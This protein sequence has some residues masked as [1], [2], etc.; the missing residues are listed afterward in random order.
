MPIR[1]RWKALYDRGIFYA[2]KLPFVY[3][4][5]P[6]GFLFEYIITFP[7][8]VMTGID[9]HGKKKKSGLSKMQ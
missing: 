8:I 7:Y 4:A 9:A 3:I 2:F 5:V 6:M 1:N